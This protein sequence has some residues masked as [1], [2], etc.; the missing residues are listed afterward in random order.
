M[1]DNLFDALQ[2]R[3]LTTETWGKRLAR[4]RGHLTLRQVADLMAPLM[5]KD[6][7]Q[8]LEALDVAPTKPKPRAHAVMLLVLYGIDPREFGLGPE[9]APAAADLRAI[10]AIRKDPLNST[11]TLWYPRAA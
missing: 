10:A 4:A 6:T 1:A 7:I 5:T 9:D 8:R 2:L 3:T 11:L